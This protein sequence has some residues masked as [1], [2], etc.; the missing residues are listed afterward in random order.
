MGADGD[1]GEEGED[2][3]MCRFI[4]YLPRVCYGLGLRYR[5]RVRVR[6]KVRVRLRVRV[7]VSV[8]V[9]ISY[10]IT[11]DVFCL[12][13]VLGLDDHP[14]VQNEEVKD[15]VVEPEHT[16]VKK[17]RIEKA[18]AK[19]ASPGAGSSTDPVHLDE[20]NFDATTSVKSRNRKAKVMK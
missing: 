18:K 10:L 15:E 8:R 20:V 17:S 11:F 14:V 6:V 16:P 7:R 4:N 5:V 1:A 19:L 13:R 12:H 3:I 9:G 2:G